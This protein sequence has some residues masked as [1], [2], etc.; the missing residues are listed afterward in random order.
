MFDEYVKYSMFI[1]SQVRCNFY[2]QNEFRNSSSDLTSLIHMIH[3]TNSRS[4]DL[5]D[6][7]LAIITVNNTSKLE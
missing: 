6:K 3:I 4:L 7:N 5:I 2:G 1:D